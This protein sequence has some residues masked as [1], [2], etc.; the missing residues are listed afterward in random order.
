MA[1]PR[2]HCKGVASEELKAQATATIDAGIQLAKEAAKRKELQLGRGEGLH[3]QHLRDQATATIDSGVQLAKEAARRKEL[4]LASASASPAAS[5]S[6]SPDP[7]TDR[8]DRLY[9][10]KGANEDITFYEWQ[11][12]PPAEQ[13]DYVK[14]KRT[15]PPDERGDAPAA[16]GS[17]RSAAQAETDRLRAVEKRLNDVVAAIGVDKSGTYDL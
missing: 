17:V 16:V 9:H 10:K 12:L 14:R 4:E 5:R 8:W 2:S 6:P 3:Q 1:A 11:T 15:F 7:S 13:S